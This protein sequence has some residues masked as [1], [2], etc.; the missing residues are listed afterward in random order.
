MAFTYYKNRG[1]RYNSL[2][3]KNMFH[4]IRRNVFMEEEKKKNTRFKAFREEEKV[5]A[6]QLKL[7]TDN[8]VREAIW[9][10]QNARQLRWYRVGWLLVGLNLGFPLMIS[11]RTTWARCEL[12]VCQQKRE[13][14]SLVFRMLKYYE[15]VNVSKEIHQSTARQ[16]RNKLYVKFRNTITKKFFKT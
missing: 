16:A 10:K 4:D 11:L 15:K 3:L 5:L 9:W 12:V 14:A 2:L 1:I 6:I 13:G 8:F 7:C